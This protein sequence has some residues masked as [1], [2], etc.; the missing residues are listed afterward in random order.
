M[1][2][3]PKT[4]WCLHSKG[5][6]LRGLETVPGKT[7]FWSGIYPA[8]MND[9]KTL[10]TDLNVFADFDPK[11]PAA[12]VNYPYL[13]LGNIQPSLQLQGPTTDARAALRRRRHHEL[14]DQPQ[15]A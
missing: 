10:V 5:V 2:L 12:Y 8:D 1:I 3:P 14:L 11:L 6:D 7:F 15:Q 4:R 13:F 9:R